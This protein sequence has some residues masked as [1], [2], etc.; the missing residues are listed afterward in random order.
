VTT[1]D[2]LRKIVFSC[3]RYTSRQSACNLMKKSPIPE[4]PE[5]LM[6]TAIC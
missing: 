5:G 2:A 6:I 3:G 1:A 4:A